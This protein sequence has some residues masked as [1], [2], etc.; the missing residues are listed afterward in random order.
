MVLKAGWRQAE[1]VVTLEAHGDS[2]IVPFAPVAIACVVTVIC[3]PPVTPGFDAAVAI[4]ET[5]FVPEPVETSQP[6]PLAAI[7][8]PEE[9]D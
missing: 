3:A 6:Q 9:A 2:R 8:V 1:N 4:D 7:A 5:Y